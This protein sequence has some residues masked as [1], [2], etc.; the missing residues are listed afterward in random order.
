[1]AGDS[2][3]AALVVGTPSGL[4]EAGGSRGR[5]RRNRA[6]MLEPNEEDGPLLGGGRDVRDVG[7]FDQQVILVA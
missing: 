4:E 1:M 2:G 5:W 6:E 7:S 3:F